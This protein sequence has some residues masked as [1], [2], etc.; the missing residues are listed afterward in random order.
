MWKTGRRKQRNYIRTSQFLFRTLLLPVTKGDIQEKQNMRLV[1]TR[2]PHRII[3]RF[4]GRYTLQCNINQVNNNPNILQEGASQLQFCSDKCLNQYKMHIFCRETEAHLEVHPHLPGEDKAGGSLIT[5]DLWLKN[6]KSPD[7]RTSSPPGSPPRENHQPQLPAVPLISVA[8]PSKLMAISD[9]GTK[10]H[11]SKI[12]K[13]H[14]KRQAVNY[15]VYKTDA[16]AELPQDL[17]IRQPPNEK[18]GESI[19]PPQEGLTDGS[20]KRRDAYPVNPHVYP[21]PRFYHTGTRPANPPIN[22]GGGLIKHPAELPPVTVL[23][24]Y[25]IVVP[26][27]L[28]IPIPIPLSG[29]LKREKQNEEGSNKRSVPGEDLDV[30][31]HKATASVPLND[32][33]TLADVAGSEEEARN[34]ISRPLRKRKRI[35]DAKPRMA[36]KKKPLAV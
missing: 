4:S 27:P 18:H 15:N 28:P 21:N 29:L 34:G 30:E 13:K 7:S 12:Q 8:P 2:P 14:R 33:Q 22:F 16:N 5:P 11:R 10:R 26:F 35:I 25:P 19:A 24:P 6:C 3:R 9:V 20:V 1:Q 32:V 17:R 23:V 36:N 31:T